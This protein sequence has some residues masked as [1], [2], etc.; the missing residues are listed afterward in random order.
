MPSKPTY[1][2]ASSGRPST[3]SATHSA[4][5]SLRLED[6][7]RINP[8]SPSPG[9]VPPVAA[10]GAKWSYSNYGYNLLGR[11]VK[12]AGGQDLST[13]VQQRITRPL[14]LHRTLLPTSG[15]GLTTPFTHGYG[16]GD[17]CPT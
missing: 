17:V 9:P 13:A 1:A 6:S 16:L 14:G 8:C 5:Q 4:W 7:A 10:P 2:S 12:L 3:P 15:N 11:V